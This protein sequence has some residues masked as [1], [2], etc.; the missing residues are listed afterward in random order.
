M[1][2]VSRGE[3]KTTILKEKIRLK[4]LKPILSDPDVKKHLEELHRQF[5]IVTIDKASN[6]FAVI[7]RR[8]YISKLLVEV[9]QNTNKTSTSKYPQI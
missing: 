3:R 2:N 4:Q 1:E 7:C 8:Y 9:S 6:N 5:F